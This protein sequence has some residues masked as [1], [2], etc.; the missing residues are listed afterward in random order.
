MDPIPVALGIV[1]NFETKL[2]LFGVGYLAKDIAED[3]LEE[4]PDGIPDF[5]YRT[6]SISLQTGPRRTSHFHLVRLDVSR[7]VFVS[8]QASQTVFINPK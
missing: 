3:D 8:Q 1:R 2:E 7:I 4:D 5:V 6:I